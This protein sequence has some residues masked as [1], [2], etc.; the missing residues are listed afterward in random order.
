MVGGC[1]DDL[2]GPS[3]SEITFHFIS[4]T[5]AAAVGARVAVDGTLVSDSLAGGNIVLPLER[6]RH[7]VIVHKDC[8]EVAPA[9]TLQVEVMP[10]HP[11]SVDFHFRQLLGLQVVSSPSGFPVYVDGVAT[12]QVT[13]ASL[14]C[15]APGAHQVRI[16]PTGPEQTGYAAVG[17]T[18]REILLGDSAA[19]VSFD[20]SFTPRPQS[21]G[22][23]FEIFTSTYCPN[24]APADFVTDTLAVDPD[25]DPAMLSIAHIH[26]YWNGFDPLHNLELAARSDYYRIMEST[27][28]NAYFNGLDKTTGTLYPDLKAIYKEN[29]RHTYGQ[30]GRIALYWIEPRVEGHLLRATLR[31]IALEDVSEYFTPNLCAFYAKDRMV[32]TDPNLNPN[33]LEYVQGAR[34]YIPS[35]PL[36]RDNPDSSLTAAGRTIDVPVT[37]DLDEDQPA[38]IDWSSGELR[39]VAYV[40]DDATK[41]I[42]Q[43]RQVKLVRR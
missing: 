1:R 29:I 13:P 10:S 14:A 16:S 5:P 34:H 26:L 23:L 30:S 40:Q 18:L 31:Y 25:F 4:D 32:I 36:V 20:L 6:G 17:D 2:G 21:R 3:A 8:V 19:V 41:E 38:S 9:E 35:V 27:A 28:P 12:G 39:L 15:L 22:V 24:C 11:A 33:H 7:T 42:L 43:C 37:F